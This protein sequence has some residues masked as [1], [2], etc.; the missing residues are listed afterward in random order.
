MTLTTS[1]KSHNVSTYMYAMCNVREATKVSFARSGKEK[2]GMD[3]EGKHD[4]D[5]EE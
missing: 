4:M 3:G 1:I 5:G 2:H